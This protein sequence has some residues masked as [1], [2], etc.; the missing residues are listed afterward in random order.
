MKTNQPNVPTVTETSASVY[1]PICTHTV[2]A[3]VLNLGKSMRVK[4]HQRCPRCSTALDAGKIL[5]L[6]RAA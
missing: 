1:C 2:Q 4:P 3:T 6:A 5:W